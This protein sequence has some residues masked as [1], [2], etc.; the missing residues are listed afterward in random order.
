MSYATTMS[1]GNMQGTP[2]VEAKCTICGYQRT[3]YVWDGRT[4]GA[5]NVNFASST[6]LIEAECWKCGVKR[7]FQ[8]V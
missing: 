1:I 7:A 6:G 5:D 8:R 3:F 4:L 2:P